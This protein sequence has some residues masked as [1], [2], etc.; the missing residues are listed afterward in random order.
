MKMITAQV[1]FRAENNS[2]GVP[3]RNLVRQKAL[4]FY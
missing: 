2:L 1:T 3:E 4:N